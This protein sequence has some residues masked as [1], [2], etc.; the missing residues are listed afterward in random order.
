MSIE[1]QLKQID[2]EIRRLV[3]FKTELRLFLKGGVEG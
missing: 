2:K 3:K 1:K